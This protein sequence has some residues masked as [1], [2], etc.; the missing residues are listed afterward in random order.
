MERGEEL[1]LTFSQQEGRLAAQSPERAFPALISFNWRVCPSPLEWAAHR[2]SV[3]WGFLSGCKLFR[4]FLF[5]V[6]VPALGGAPGKSRKL[7]LSSW[8]CLAELDWANDLT[9]GAS[10]HSSIK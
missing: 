9:F 3:G 5:F 4:S 8:L 2:G 1:G 6:A 10:D 7:G